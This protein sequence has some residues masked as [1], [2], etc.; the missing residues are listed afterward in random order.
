MTALSTVITVGD[1]VITGTRHRA[2]HIAIRPGAA[3]YWQVSWLPDRTLDRNKAITAM[4]A[5]E[6]IQPTTIL[7]EPHTLD[8]RFH[9][10]SPECWCSPAFT[11]PGT[12]PAMAWVGPPWPTATR[13]T[14]R[15]S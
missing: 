6:L 1:R 2:R 10:R 3:E 9:V 12:T 8:R 5:I 4:V 15:A 7:T 11:I 13:S 14:P